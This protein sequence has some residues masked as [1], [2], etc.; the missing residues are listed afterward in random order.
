MC[1][2]GLGICK[3]RIYDNFLALD[4]RSLLRV[5][6][7]LA[8]MVGHGEV[9][10]AGQ[11]VSLPGPDAST[12]TMANKPFETLASDMQQLAKEHKPVPAPLQ[13][14]AAENTTIP[15]IDKDKPNMKAT[16]ETIDSAPAKEQ[17]ATMP[18]QNLEVK[19]IARPSTKDK[20]ATMS[21]QDSE[22]KEVA[23]P[24]EYKQ[25]IE[26]LPQDKQAAEPPEDKQ[27]SHS[28]EDIQAPKRSLD[29]STAS[30]RVGAFL[31]QQKAIKMAKVTTETMETKTDQSIEIA[32]DLAPLPLPPADMKNVE[33]ISA[34]FQKPP[35]KR[36]RKPKSPKGKKD[37]KDKHETKKRS[38]KTQATSSKTSRK[39]APHDSGEEMNNETN[40]V[41]DAPEPKPKRRRA[42][43][44]EAANAEKAPAAPKKAKPL[45]IDKRKQPEKTTLKRDT[46]P[47]KARRKQKPQDEVKPHDVSQSQ[48]LKTKESTPIPAGLPTSSRRRLRPL[49][50]PQLTKQETKYYEAMKLPPDANDFDEYV[51]QSSATAIAQLN[52]DNSKPDPILPV[53]GGK[54]ERENEVPSGADPP[55]DVEQPSKPAKSAEQKARNSRKSCAYQKKLREQ[56]NAGIPL[57]QAK[58]AARKVTRLALEMFC[59]NAHMQHFL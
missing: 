1:V 24:L 20:A 2:C 15:N 9:E 19:A 42:T 36:G 4:M 47:T 44:A 30:K 58:A 59:M 22:G 54:H 53:P 13:T 33:Y 23:Q 14:R 39:K 28:S 10:H 12:P 50:E 32:E 29:L 57:E 35:K 51:H 46:K 25:A 3:S 48:E 17:A 55:P 7:F 31:K 11:H 56:K 41:V 49:C 16:Q 40:D 6:H 8:E 43:K 45:E 37:E 26:P 27:A 52:G 5:T 38:Q 21:S 34:D 18:A